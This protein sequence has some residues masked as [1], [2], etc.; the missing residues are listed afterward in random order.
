MLT[1]TRRLALMA[2]LGLSFALPLSPVAAEPLTPIRFTLDWKYQGVHAWYFLAQEKG[3][4][5]EEGLEV[6]IDQGEGSAATVTRIMSGAYDAGFGDINAIIQ[7]AAQKP[8]EAPVMVYHIYNKAPFAVVAKAGSG[9]AGPKDLVGKKVGGPAGSAATR[10]LPTLLERNGLDPAKV[11]ILNMQPSLQEQMLI[12]DEV[13]ASLVFNVT[14]YVNLIQQGQDPDKGFRWISFADHGVD[15]YSNGV[16]VSQSL[17]RE[18]PRAV[19]GLV[20]AI[21]RAI[22]D[23]MADPAAAIQALVKIEPLVDAKSELRRL[24]FAFDAVMITPETREIGLGDVSDERLKRAIQLIAE[25]YKLP[26]Q[27]APGQVYDRSFLPPL[28]ER[29]ITRSAG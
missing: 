1:I 13:A 8:G 21:N 5:R 3:Y 20:R 2:G 25:T 17:A 24:Q 26:G 18:K 19:M 10:L 11:E 14:S 15:L 4:F 22:L 16:M 23:S 6:T 27:S 28:K 7:Q 9:I 12:R 29:S